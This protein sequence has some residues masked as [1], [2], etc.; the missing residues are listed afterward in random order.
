VIDDRGLEAGGAPRRV[1]RVRGDAR[2]APAAR[3]R[4]GLRNH[5]VD[6]DVAR[7]EPRPRLRRLKVP[8]KPGGGHHVVEQRIVAQ[9]SAVDRQVAVPGRLRECEGRC[10][11]VHVDRLRA[12]DHN[13]IEMRSESFERVQQGGA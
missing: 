3:A 13:R 2:P 8:S 1:A 10:F 5:E 12:D 6:G 11:G 4:E 7:A 9:G